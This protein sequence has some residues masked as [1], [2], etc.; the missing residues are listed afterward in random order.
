MWANL[1]VLLMTVK[2]G[3]ESFLCL[4]I[5]VEMTW[6]EDQGEKRC[7]EFAVFLYFWDD[8]CLVTS[9][10]MLL[11]MIANGKEQNASFATL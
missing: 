6:K 11:Q 9:Q 2:L 10:K 8:G 3:P 7:T 5:S 1:G 4:G